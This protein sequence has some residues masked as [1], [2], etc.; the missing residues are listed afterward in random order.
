ML[1]KFVEMKETHLL[2][3]EKSHLLEVFKNNGYN[4]THSLKAFQRAYKYSREK[5]ACVD[6][7]SKVYLSFIQGNLDNIAHILR[8]NNVSSS[9]KPLRT[10]GNSL[11]SIKDPIDP[12]DMKGVYLIPCS[13]GTPYIGETDRLIS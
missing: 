10:I 13:C 3:Q 2:E 5:I 9:F 7:I 6:P 1:P 4:R 12:K 11:G 8:Q